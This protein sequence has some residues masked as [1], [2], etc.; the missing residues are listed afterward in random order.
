MRP[1]AWLIVPALMAGCV[2]M[3]EPI[4]D[5]VTEGFQSSAIDHVACLPVLDFRA[6]RQK[7]LSLDAWSHP[8]A[9]RWL[10]ER[11]Y[12]STLIADRTVVAS[13]QNLPTRD[14]LDAAIPQFKPALPDRWVM[15]LCLLDSYS[16]LRF[17]SSGNAEMMAYLLD[18]KTGAVVWRHYAVGQD[19]QGGFVGMVL[20]PVM[21]RNA[22]QLAVV[23]LI[24]RFPRKPAR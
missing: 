10:K 17:G 5:L 6:D 2:N 19:G 18:T 8:V 3:P 14:A 12:E 11:G 4:P 1:F 7:A 21:E 23:E 16:K 20:T 22:I 13:L 9:A 15:I 24:K